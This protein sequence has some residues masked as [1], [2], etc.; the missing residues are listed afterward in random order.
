MPYR[1]GCGGG[2]SAATAAGKPDLEKRLLRH[3][4]TGMAWPGCSLVSTE[5]QQN[6]SDSHGVAWED[7]LKVGPQLTAAYQEKKLH[8]VINGHTVDL[9]KMKV[10]GGPKIRCLNSKGQT[11][12]PLTHPTQK[13]VADLNN[14][15]LTTM[16]LEIL[17]S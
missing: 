15:D 10:R 3:P 1:E 12:A 4:N 7:F 14:P 16:G 5:Q 17:F 2:R 13:G 8:V 9:V 11:L 6:K